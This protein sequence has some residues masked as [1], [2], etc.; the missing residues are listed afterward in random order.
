MAQGI[1]PFKYEEEKHGGG[2]TALSGLPNYLELSYALGLAESICDHVH[3]R[4]K[5]QGFTDREMV[6]SLILL[7]LVGG[8]CVLDLRVLEGDEGLC[9]VLDRV[10]THGMARKERSVLERRWRKDRRRTFPSATSVF[11]YLDSFHDEAQEDLRKPGKA[12]IPKPNGHLVGLKE[13]NGNFAAHV[14]RRSPQAVA[15]L[16]MDA[17]LVQSTK[18]EALYCYKG[19]KAY[20]P[21][22]TYWFEKDLVLHSEFR[23]GNVPAGYEQLRV[24]KEALELVPS[25][26][27][28]VYL[29]SDTAGYQHDLLKYC[30]EGQ[31]ARFGVIEFAIGADVTAEFKSMVSEVE[32]SDWFRL[33][34][35]V[36]GSLVDSGQEYA[37]IC[38]VPSRLSRKKSDPEYRFIAIRE[39]L[40]QPDLPTLDLQREL[41]FPTM[42][43]DSHRYKVTGIVTN[44][45]IPGDELIQWYRQ[46]CGKSEEVHAVMKEDLAGGTLPSG[47]FG[48]NAAWWQI[49][50]LALNLHSA[51]KHVVLGGDW[52]N[53][54]FKAIRFWLINLPGRV[55]KS[56]RELI[57]RLVG[58]HASNQTLLSMRTRMA[59][60]YDTG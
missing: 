37:E 47:K 17:T 45:A 18:Q 22:Q 43:M 6:M 46:R 23:D 35:E 19:F 59:N 57:I 30:A 2:L 14:Q 36:N 49:M 41:P 53:K 15:T 9:R 13:L 42:D 29:R 1:L 58:R 54:R 12:F 27:D 31:N 50:I 44:R 51:M 11:R 26:V 3:V 16:D 8:D 32:E 38:F 10:K 24:F 40:S 39:P 33:H 60:L 5:G 34:R 28:R 21:L 7:N 56:G 48:V 25:G 52:V 4:D 20:Q 55:A